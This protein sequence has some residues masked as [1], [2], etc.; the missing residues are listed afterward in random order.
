LTLV[1][2]IIPGMK[3]LV[4][5]TITLLSVWACRKDDTSAIKR[6]APEDLIK[7]KWLLDSLDTGNG[8]FRPKDVIVVKSF[9]SADSGTNTH[10][11][12]RQLEITSFKYAVSG[13]TM[14]TELKDGSNTKT[15]YQM[16]WPEENILLLEALPPVP[17]ENLRLKKQ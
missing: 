4:L 1:K 13:D 14:K 15:N 2:H 6:F 7:T 12:T 10:Y 8:Y 17:T 5:L 11:Y 9:V 3:K 16:K